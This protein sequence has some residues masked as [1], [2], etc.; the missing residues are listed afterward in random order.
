MK[1][2]EICPGCGADLTRVGIDD[3]ARTDDVCSCGKVDYDHVVEQ[4]WHKKCL[5]EYLQENPEKQTD[6]RYI[7]K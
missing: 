1:S 5:M 3:L 4:S 2:Q 6:Y 7:G